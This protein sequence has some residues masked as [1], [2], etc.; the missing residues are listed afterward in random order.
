MTETTLVHTHARMLHQRTLRG[1][2]PAELQQQVDIAD[3][4]AG[5]TVPD[6]AR[7]ELHGSE[8]EIVRGVT[9]AARVAAFDMRT[10]AHMTAGLLPLLER[11][12]E[13]VGAVGT[14]AWAALATCA[15]A[16]VEQRV[17]TAIAGREAAAVA[18]VERWLDDLRA[19]CRAGRS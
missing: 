9:L 2:S 13:L 7:I 11:R 3:G 18:E 1:P 14:E 4:R 5:P 10:L 16:A 6:G 17:D 19:R 8:A 15:R 12:P